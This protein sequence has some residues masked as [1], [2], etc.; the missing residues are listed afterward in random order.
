VHL[1]INLV[2][3][4]R[5]SV[6]LRFEACLLK[7]RTKFLIKQMASSLR[8]SKEHMSVFMLGKT[9]QQSVQKLK[10]RRTESS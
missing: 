3:I 9:N 2:D 5:F 6:Y 1:P 8:K 4:S 7:D 10:S